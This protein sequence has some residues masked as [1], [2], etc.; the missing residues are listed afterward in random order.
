[1]PT[2]FP[3]SLEKFLDSC[4]ASGQHKAT[5][6]ILKYVN[7]DFNRLHQDIYGDIGFPFQVACCL[8]KP[9]RDFEGGEFIISE[10][11]PRMQSRATVVPLEKGDAVIFANQFRPIT[12]ARGYARVT[13]RHGVSE[14]RRG[15]RYCL[16]VIFHDAG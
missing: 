14:V 13:V 2:N 16:G 6:L 1:M 12:G 11:R 10:Q 5:P 4:H 3:D 9:R 15:T 7:G 8:S